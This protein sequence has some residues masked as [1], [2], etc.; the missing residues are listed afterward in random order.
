[1]SQHAIPTRTFLKKGDGEAS[2]PAD[3]RAFISLKPSDIFGVVD[4]YM[5]RS[6][7]ANNSLY[8][9][10]TNPFDGSI[11]Y[12]GQLPGQS[13]LTLAVGSYELE[14][15]GSNLVVRFRANTEDQLRQVMAVLART[16]PAFLSI[17]LG[18]FVWIASCSVK[19]GDV[20]Y[21]MPLAY[22]TEPPLAIV[23]EE[24]RDRHIEQ[25][26]RDAFAVPAGSDRIMIAFYYWRQARRLRKTQPF[27][28][29]LLPEVVLNLCKAVEIVLNQT[30]TIAR[31]MAEEFGL[32]SEFI[33][34]R[35]IP[36]LIIRNKYDVGHASTATLDGREI[37]LLSDFADS[38]FLHV[39][40]LLQDL[41]DRVASGSI[42]LRPIGNTKS[43]R[44]EFFELLEGY[45]SSEK[46]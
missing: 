20:T 10:H 18:D 40:R 27:T 5:P 13:R 26:L 2:F 29:S 24:E 44:S 32:E 4:P 25:A 34:S 46:T 9:V 1:M 14:L 33:E 17:R 12:D 45:L 19:V 6:A 35:I 38:A 21:E 30:H 43:K 7:V 23:I 31:T 11:Y 8:E 15:T 22:R 16:I 36:L 3:A 37:K 41:L 28:V 39:F 42:T